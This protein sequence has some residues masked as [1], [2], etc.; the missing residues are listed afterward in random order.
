M[1]DMFVDGVVAAPA[2]T[3][4]GETAPAAAPGSAVAG[5]DPLTAACT[6]A[7]DSASTLLL[8]AD[9]IA[10]T[11]E[12]TAVSTGTSN[13]QNLTQ[14]EQNNATELRDPLGQAGSAGI[15]T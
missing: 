9:G 5:V 14:T 4:T 12:A 6:T 13:V 1:A 2:F 8:N 7:L 3:A 10:S 15:W 11:D